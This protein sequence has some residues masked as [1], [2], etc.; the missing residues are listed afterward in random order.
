MAYQG[1]AF[2]KNGGKMMGME[3][4][5]QIRNI[6]AYPEVS[7]EIEEKKVF[8]GCLYLLRDCVQKAHL[9]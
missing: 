4:F 5:Q 2:E 8:Q 7:G 3:A 9:F 1:K 6:Y